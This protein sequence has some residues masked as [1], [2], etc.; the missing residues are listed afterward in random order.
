MAYQ[1]VSHHSL[2]L[3]A[4]ADMSAK[5]YCAVAV[6]SAGKAIIADA[7]DQVIGI[8]Q[9]N[10]GAGQAATVAFGGIS[11][12]KFGGTVAAGARVTSNAS[13]EIVA[14]TTAGDAVLGVALVGGASGEIGTILV[15]AF[16]F[17]ALA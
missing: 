9:N 10:P 13:G 5:Q 1:N 12:V 15:H 14:A 16:P 11:K 7:D 2:S 4:N 6:N 3:V 17:V 8:L